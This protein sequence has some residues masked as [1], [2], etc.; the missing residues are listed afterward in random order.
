MSEWVNNHAV[1]PYV[2]SV[3]CPTFGNDDER[4]NMS[5]LMV[6]F[7]KRVGPMLKQFR[8][9]EQTKYYS[10]ISGAEV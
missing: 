4:Q 9:E 8:G 6:N 2:Q 3:G 7:K 5:G 1:K 10:S